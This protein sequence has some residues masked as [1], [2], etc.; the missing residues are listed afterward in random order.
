MFQ[1]V[2]IGYVSTHYE[3][4]K[5]QRTLAL[6]VP[7]KYIVYEGG[8]LIIYKAKFL[9][10]QHTITQVSYIRFVISDKGREEITDR[11]STF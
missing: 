3:Q 8:L 5:C 2:S 6:H 10:S 1:L 7:I 4:V 11:D 9:K